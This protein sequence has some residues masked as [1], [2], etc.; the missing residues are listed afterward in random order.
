MLKHKEMQ[1]GPSRC[2]RLGHIATSF[3]SNNCDW[4]CRSEVWLPVYYQ[5]SARSAVR[6]PGDPIPDWCPKHKDSA[7]FTFI[8]DLS[9]FGVSAFAKAFLWKITRKPKF[10]YRTASSTPLNKRS[11]RHGNDKFGPK[12]SESRSDWIRDRSLS[13]KTKQQKKGFSWFHIL[14]NFEV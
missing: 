12:T 14:G 1:L 8:H 11:D 2:L 5:S 13:G 7:C 4:T 9:D 10:G 3:C 6:C